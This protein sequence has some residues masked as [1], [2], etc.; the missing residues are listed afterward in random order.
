MPTLQQRASFDEVFAFYR[1]SGF[2]YPAKL[3]ALA[4][5]MPALERT[6]RRLLDDDADLFRLFANRA[7]DGELLNAICAF[8]YVPGTWQGQHLVSRRRHEY[9]GTL[10]VLSDLVR[11]FHD[12]GVRHA[13][14]SFR[15][16]N[17]G[18]NRLF[19]GVA[20]R[21]PAHL[22]DLSVVDY[23]L[24]APGAERLPRATVSVER[25][26]RADAHVAVE[27]YER[28]LHPVELAAL[29]LDDLELDG[30]GASFAAH[31]LHRRRRVLVAGG[32]SGVLGA[33]IVNEASEGINLSFLENAIEHLHVVPELSARRRRHVWQALAA[34]ALDAAREQHE[35]AVAT[36]DPGDRDLAIEA[37]LIPERPKQ[38]AVLTVT[39]QGR[40]F[41]RS[42]ECFDAYYDALRARR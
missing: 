17:P 30:L 13:R 41:L 42:I 5:R 7:P 9:L 27:F 25:L 31:G 34:A 38:Y 40:G 6:W 37:G 22:A 11:W 3:A 29:D 8:E 16:N 28:L 39:R 24:V 12:A 33:C 4:P 35:D 32:A 2:L 26:T 18:T 10:G 14:L 1:D 21:L 15:P 19:G 23:A 36:L 20:Q